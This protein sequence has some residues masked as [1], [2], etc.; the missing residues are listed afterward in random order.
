VKNQDW[1]AGEKTTELPA[2][3]DLAA[4]SVLVT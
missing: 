3:A 2:A 4:M 1:L